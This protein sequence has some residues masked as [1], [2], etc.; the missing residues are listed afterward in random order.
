MTRRALFLIAALAIVPTLRGWP[1]APAAEAPKS[2]LPQRISG[3]DLWKLSTELSEPDGN[4]RSDNL[5]S[6]EMYMQRVIPELVRVAKPGRAYLG[7]GPEQNFT[8]I[9]AVKPAIAFIIDI[10]R[11]NLRLHLMY[12][13]LFELSADR[14]EFVSRL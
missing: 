7:V 14:A 6:N 11:G 5:V 9:A 8:Y 2:A 4:F 10:R 13:A 12:K 1:A 3:Q